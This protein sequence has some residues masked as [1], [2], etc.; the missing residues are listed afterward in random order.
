MNN[1]TK[2][3]DQQAQIKREVLERCM[4]TDYK[5]ESVRGEY[6]II[7]Y[8]S[9]LTY[10][11]QVLI[12]ISYFMTKIQCLLRVLRTACH[13]HEIMNNIPREYF[14]PSLRVQNISWPFF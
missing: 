2:D 6:E 4:S 3:A 12:D 13:H 7:R 14:S 11:S 10:Q 8:R 1:A 9:E 5:E